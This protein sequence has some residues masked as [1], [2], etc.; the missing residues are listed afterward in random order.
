MNPIKQQIAIAKFV[1]W[2]I[3]PQTVGDG[4]RLMGRRD[5]SDWLI[6]PEYHKCLNAMHEAE[7]FLNAGQCNTY[8]GHLFKPKGRDGVWD[9]VSARRATH[10]SGPDRAECFLRTVNL[11]EESND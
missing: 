8:L 9:I 2:E 5:G 3:L 11:W 10:A 7:R 4:H 1:G 6:V